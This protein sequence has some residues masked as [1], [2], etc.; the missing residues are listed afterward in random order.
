M[1]QFIDTDL[2]F[3]ILKNLRAYFYQPCIFCLYRLVDE[4]FRGHMQE[5]VCFR[6]SARA[7]LALGS[8][9]TL[10]ACPAT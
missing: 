10:A 4:Q 2:G 6:L 9:L 8:G 1:V 5:E 7:R 3:D